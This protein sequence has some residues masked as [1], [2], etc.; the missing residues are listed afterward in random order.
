MAVGYEYYGGT[1]GDAPEKV[2]FISK[3]IDPVGRRVIGH[4]DGSC[5]F[6]I[7]ATP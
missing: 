1:T 3:Y 4:V 5:V 6:E 2:L 7:P